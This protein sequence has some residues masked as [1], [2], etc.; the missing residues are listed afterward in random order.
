VHLPNLEDT[1]TVEPAAYESGLTREQIPPG[2][3]KLQSVELAWL[4]W[5]QRR[6]LAKLSVRGLIVFTLLAFMLPKRYEATSQLMPPD[7]NSSSDLISALPALS[8]SSEPSGAAGG[9]VMGLANKLLGLNSSGQLIVGVLRSR[10]VEDRLIERFGLMNLYSAKYPE[11]ARRKLESYTTIKEDTQTGIIRISV[12]DKDP[13]RAAAMAQ[14]YSEELNRTLSEVNTSAAHRERVLIEQRISE[15]RQQLDA[16]AKD[17][18]VFASQNTA[19]DIPEQAKAMVGAAAD[20]QAQLIEAQSMLRGLQQIYTDHNPRVQQIQGQVTELEL[21]L[22]KLGGKNVTTDQGSS[23]PKDELYP[24]IRQLPLL[25]VRYLDL[26][27]RTKIDEAVYELLTKEYELAKMEEARNTPSVQVLDQASI[28][29]EKVSP[30]RLWIMLGGTCFCSLL[31]VTWIV[32]GAHWAR[33]DP[34][35]PWMIFAQEVCTTTRAHVWDS[36]WALRIRAR[37]SRNWGRLRWRR[38]TAD[39]HDSGKR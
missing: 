14:A 24:S 16:S 10:T 28:P 35:E 20:L 11:N 31:G 34:Q 26:Y 27:R 17:F 13:T 21:Q 6:F 29:K 39:S 36:P 7:F 23:L 33:T 5:G 32:A 1:Y 15:V 8:S 2:F 38:S 3:K 12:E 37:L 9:S 4:I 22:N 18:S 25:G 30:H 19:I